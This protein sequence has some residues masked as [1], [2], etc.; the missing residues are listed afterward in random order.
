MTVVFVPVVTFTDLSSAPWSPQM[1]T[2]M[3]YDSDVAVTALKDRVENAA[4][5][6]QAALRV[7]R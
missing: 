4:A 7:S 3:Q 6:R 2:T 5:V 1:R